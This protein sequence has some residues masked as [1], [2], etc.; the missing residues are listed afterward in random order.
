[1]PKESKKYIT[2][3]GR[4]KRS[5]ARI[6]LFEGKGQT[7]VNGKPINDY[8]K[9]ISE[10][11]YLRPLHVTQTVGKY[12]ATAI[13]AGGG[14][15]GQVGAFVHG[16]SRALVKADEEKYKKPLKANNL[17]TRDSRERERRKAGLAHGARAAKQSP[18]R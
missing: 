13:T 5:I 8:F 6:R 3:L 11:I 12:Y 7:L 1:M 17:L 9:D 10:I 15:Y 4:R 2:T 16:L 14:I 18:K